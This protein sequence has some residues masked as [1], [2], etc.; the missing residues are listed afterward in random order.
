MICDRVLGNVFARDGEAP[1]TPPAEVVELTWFECFRRAVRKKTAGGQTVRLLPP[2]GTTLL[3]GD[4]LGDEHG[5]AAAVVQ[6]LPCEVLFAKPA[7]QVRMGQ[8]ATELGNLHLPVEVRPD[9]TLLVLPDGPAEAVLRRYAVPYEHITT[10]FSPLRASVPEEF[11]L[12]D[13][14][15]LTRRDAQS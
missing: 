10:R 6:V 4:V 9:G 15:K 3:H 5:V 14:F 7:D 8:V 13:D 1:A 12:A 2:L 11:R